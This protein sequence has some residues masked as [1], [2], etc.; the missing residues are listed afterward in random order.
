MFWFAQKSLPECRS[1][2][3]QELSQDYRKSVGNMWQI[4][5]LAGPNSQ[6]YTS[7]Y[8]QEFQLSPPGTWDE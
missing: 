7:R 2:P 1:L 8:S 4:F 6:A 3:R 5:A